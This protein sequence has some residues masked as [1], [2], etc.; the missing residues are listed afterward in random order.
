SLIEAPTGHPISNG[1][2][3]NIVGVD[4]NLGA[5]QD[6]GGPTETQALLAG[7]PAID[8]G[9]NPQMLT[10]DQRGNARVAG[11]GIDIGAFESEPS[12]SNQAPDALNDAISTDED[13]AF[14]GTVFADNGSGADSDPDGDIFSVIEVNEVAA[15]VGTQIVLPSGALLTLNADGTLSYDPNGQFE[16]LA[17][18]DA[19]ADSLTYTIDD[20]NGGTDTATA[21][22]TVNGVNDAPDATNQSFA[23][24]ENT[25][26]GTSVGAIAAS[27][28]DA[29][30]VLTY[31]IAGGTGSTAFAVNSTTGKITVADTA[32]L[33]FEATTSF[34]LDV[35]VSDGTLT[36]TAAIAID[37][38]DVN[39]APVVADQLF[40]LDENSANGTPVGTIAASD[41]DAG[42]IL[43]YGITGGTGSSAFDVNDTTGEITVADSS[44]LDFE[45]TPSFTLDVEVS[46]GSAT[47]TATVTVDL[48]DVSEV[49]PTVSIAP[50]SASV[51]E[52]D[53][54]ALVFLFTV[55]LSE[56]NTE[57][58]TVNFSTNDGTA[59]VIDGDYV[60]NDGT[61]VIEPGAPTLDS[62]VTVLVLGDTNVEAD[63]TFTL[64]LDSATNATIDPAGATATVTILNDDT[65]PNLP[66]DAFDDALTTN[67]NT[68]F[69]GNVLLD[70]GSGADS[71]PEGD[72]L[73]AI[74]VNGTAANIG[75]QITLASGALLPSS[76]TGH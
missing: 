10:T 65:A 41:P 58:V 37:L 23:I 63:E 56:P 21:T 1:V 59:T 71:D 67:E 61:L 13:T 60:D 6:N 34:T 20:G 31:T 35:E 49:L 73:V 69:S 5:L 68:A 57:L 51:P 4:P 15:N 29:G 3:G 8:A 48:N 30:A 54:G 42:A 46:D 28:P 32:Q 36:D 14:G 19:I 44:L 22:I 76:P 66:P 55:S 52:G 9:A 17:V 11:A 40:A 45:T 64:S 53:S 38:N 47:A 70:N 39:E 26:N 12:G 25:A 16:S 2:N 74:E 75:N 43:S 27:D 24:A 62:I 33:D 18:G 7:S 72:T 50:T